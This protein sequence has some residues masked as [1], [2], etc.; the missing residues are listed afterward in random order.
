MLCMFLCE[1]DFQ[2]FLEPFSRVLGQAKSKQILITVAQSDPRH[3]NCLHRLGILLGI[4]DWVKD[5]HKK[6]NPPQSQPCNTYTTPVDQ[7]KVRI[8]VGWDLKLTNINTSAVLVLN[9]FSFLFSWLQSNLIDSESS[10][11]SA[12]NMSEDEYLEENMMDNSFASAHLNQ[13]PQQGDWK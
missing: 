5:Y 1:F 10:S 12:L 3:M 13:S 4:T 2:V 7:A 8:Q 11:L 6:L 9:F